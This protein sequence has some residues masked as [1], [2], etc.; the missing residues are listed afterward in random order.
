MN[1]KRVAKHDDLFCLCGC[2]LSW[3]LLPSEDDF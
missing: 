3:G 1:P 2:V